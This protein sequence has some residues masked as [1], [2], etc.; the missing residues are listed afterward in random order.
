M[1]IEA[2]D[3]APA[4]GEPTD[5]ESS[6]SGVRAAAAGT[7]TAKAGRGIRWRELWRPGRW[8]LLVSLVGLNAWWLW[9]ESRPELG[10]DTISTWIA[11][12]R[13]REV[14]QALRQRLARSPH[15]GAARILLAR[16]LGQRHD[17]L[18][19][20]RELHRIPFWWPD[21][22]KWSLMEAGAFQELGRMADAE[23]AWKS[24]VE[25]DPLH[26]VEPRLATVATHDLLELY[27]VEGR[28]DD[29]VQLIWRRYGQSADRDEREKLLNMRLRTELE[30]IAPTVAAA[31][32][33]GYLAADP[34]D[35]EARLGLAK[36]QSALNHPE[37]ARRQLE[38]CLQQRPEDA[39]CWAAYLDLLNA[40]GDLDGLKGAVA[41]LPESLA[42]NP[43]ALKHRARLREL[44][45]QWSEAAALYRRI[46]RVSPSDDQ[47]YFHLAQAE[48]RL[49]Q[50]GPAQEH[51]RRWQAL[52]NA[53]TELGRAYQAVLDLRASAPDTPKHH[54]AI[55]DLAR[56]CEALGW[57][58]DAEG[59]TQLAPDA[60]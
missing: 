22:G 57:K 29:A 35:W 53:R 28:W 1:T 8:I 7:R 21:R 42:E 37:E 20:A 23:T 16:L 9:L 43:A 10:L 59:W 6:A 5:R 19:C 40:S 46:L 45:R 44:D 41:R 56:I 12:H 14:E 38:I 58:R 33:D 30:R 17:M 48:D 32:M 34:G 54:A 31:K 47:A 25:D 3:A 36:A 51:R 55:R 49:D 11:Q 24:L 60:S 18:V 50:P 15:D 52:R 27:A 4:T 13:D 39:R 2:P 26:P